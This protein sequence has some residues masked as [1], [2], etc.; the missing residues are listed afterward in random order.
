MTKKVEK[1]SV[2]KIEI[3]EVERKVL[4]ESLRT[5]AGFAKRHNRRAPL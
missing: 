5:K 3:E 2:K 4:P 1:Q